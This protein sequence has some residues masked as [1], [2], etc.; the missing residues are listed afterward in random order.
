MPAEWHAANAAR[1]AAVRDAAE[2]VELIGGG[3]DG[4][5]GVAACVFAPDTLPVGGG[6]YQ[7][8]L[9]AARTRGRGLLELTSAGAAF[10]WPVGS[11][12]DIEA[13]AGAMAEA[14]AQIW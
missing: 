13:G 12:G 6:R 14:K 1:R 7:I 4:G 9:D 8:V 11:S 10:L 3:D 5:D 2:H